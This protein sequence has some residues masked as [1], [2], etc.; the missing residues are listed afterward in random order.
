MPV[1]VVDSAHFSAAL[2][3]ALHDQNRTPQREVWTWTDAAR[4]F[5]KVLEGTNA[6]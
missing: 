4:E 5:R 1:R 6:E 3:E 2:R